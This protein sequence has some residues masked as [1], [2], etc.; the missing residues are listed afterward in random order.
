MASTEEPS[1]PSSLPPYSEMIVAAIEAL[2]E[3]S[4]SSESSISKYMEATY[5]SLPSTHSEQLV[6]ELTRMKESGELVVVEDNYRLPETDPP[7][8][9][10]RGRPPKP[11][12]PVPEAEAMPV[13]RPRGRPP[14]PKDPLAVAVAKAA[15]G[16][17]KR[18]GRPPKNPRP[19]APSP[20]PAATGA[21]V[22]VK[23]GRGRPPKVKPQL[24]DV[25]FG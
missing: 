25:E 5:G 10:G 19:S 2:D 23:R 21:V 16:L 17:P 13:S 24:A 4:G 22:G 8:K 1:D 3:K 15:H 9:R 20:A 18:R 6:E 7:P 12:T 11:K 14:K